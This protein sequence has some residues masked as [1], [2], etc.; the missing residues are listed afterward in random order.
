MVCYIPLAVFAVDA[1][2]S[3]K[4][5][6]GGWP[7]SATWDLMLYISETRHDIIAVYSKWCLLGRHAGHRGHHS[8]ITV[9]QSTL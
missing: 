6:G 9:Y 3:S 5:E 2:E 8:V 1:D 4:E 7:I